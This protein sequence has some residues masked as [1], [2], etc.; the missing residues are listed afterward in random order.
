MKKYPLIKKKKFI[1][2]NANE[3]IKIKNTFQ[4]IILKIIPLQRPA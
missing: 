3:K 1:F 4:D 2:I